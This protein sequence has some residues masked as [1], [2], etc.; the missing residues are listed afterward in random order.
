MHSRNFAFLHSVE[1]QTWF[2]S[3]I[4]AMNTDTVVNYKSESSE[5]L[6]HAQ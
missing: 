2:P 3:F 6:L 5:Y 4:V 1:L